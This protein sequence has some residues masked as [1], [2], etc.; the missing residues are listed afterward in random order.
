MNSHARV[1][2]FKEFENLIVIPNTANTYAACDARSGS[3]LAG[4]QKLH[5]ARG[6]LVRQ[7]DQS[8]HASPSF[9]LSGY[10]R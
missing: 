5:E 1:L 7:T 8:F 9:L 3:Q 10:R 4:L 6:G 2:V